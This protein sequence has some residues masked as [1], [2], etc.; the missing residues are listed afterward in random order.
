MYEARVCVCVMLHM[1]KGVGVWV[2]FLILTFS[3]HAKAIAWLG[4][5]KTKVLRH[6][7]LVKRRGLYCL[8][9][10]RAVA[11]LCTHYW[12]LEKVAKFSPKRQQRLSSAYPKVV[13]KLVQT[14]RAQSNIST[15][16]G[17]VYL[18]RVATPSLARM[19]SPAN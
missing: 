4:Q 10:L 17:C 9:L 11:A 16:I 18:C 19:H 14:R 7:T 5:R 12:M 8:S 6:E 3:S 2:A 1:C 13:I 15:Y